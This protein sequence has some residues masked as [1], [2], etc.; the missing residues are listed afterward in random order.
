MSKI[1]DN[2]AL[3]P[4]PFNEDAK[5]YEKRN[6]SLLK[7]G[8]ELAF[9]EASHLV[10]TC[11]F[12]S[13]ENEFTSVESI[14]INPDNLSDPNSN[15]VIGYQPEYFKHSTSMEGFYQEDIR[16]INAKLAMLLAGFCSYKVFIG[17]EKF[18]IGQPDEI[19]NDIIYYPVEQC[20]SN[21]IS[22]FENIK[23]N[24]SK[25]LNLNEPEIYD[26]VLKS[27]AKIERHMGK[28]AINDSIR[29][30]K[31]ILIKETKTINGSKLKNI[32]REVKRLC[33]KIREDEIQLIK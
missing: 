32:I 21:N 30:V 6:P 10:F 28:Q 9:H 23:K 24:L 25:N 2:K 31:N 22:D 16:R 17:N 5:I 12:K 27:I 11:L 1:L 4:L 15:I 7:L 13:V 3:K 19:S 26:F 20:L 8:D 14:S 18:F 29:F 33:T